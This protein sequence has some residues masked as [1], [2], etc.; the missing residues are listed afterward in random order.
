MTSS[1]SFTDERHGMAAAIGRCFRAALLLAVVGLVA[2]ACGSDDA[3]SE[4]SLDL[5]SSPISELLGLDIALRSDDVVAL[6][7]AAERGV[8]TCM[9][10]AGF[11]YLPV[12]FASQLDEAVGFVDP[13]SREYAERNG[14]GISIGPDVGP[15][16]PDSIVDPNEGIRAAL[17][18]TELASYQQALY[19]DSP[20]EDEQLTLADGTGCVAESYRTVYEA[21]A[22]L[23]GV[24]EF[25]A[26]FAPELSDL[27]DRFRSDPRFVELEEQWAAC[28]AEQGFEVATRQDIF[29]QLS[30]QMSQVT[31]PV[32][33]PGEDPP[34]ELQEQMDE[35]AEWERRAAVAEWDCNQ[36][37]DDEMQRLR[38][39]YEALF[40]DENSDRLPA[41][42]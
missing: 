40:L 10:A 27:E 7:A 36:P 17:S 28:M 20:D 3:A 15:P 35:V 19:G 29:V 41:G 38:Y 6:E 9:Q 25:F 33:E 26:E 37:V 31:G 13:E 18:A 32:L 4:V 14:Y 11:E 34:A 39:G 1:L 30:E 2:S 22:E 24:E 8:Q 12:D 5:S 21:Q 23:G 42:S 16:N